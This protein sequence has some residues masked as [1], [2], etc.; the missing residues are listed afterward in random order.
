MEQQYVKVQLDKVSFELRAEVDFT[1]LREMGRVFRVFDQQDSGN[2]SF[3][4]EAQGER[5]FVKYAG[6]R[7]TQYDGNPQDA[8]SR[9][10]NAVPIYYDL[11]HPTL[12]QIRDHFPAGAG[13]AVVFEWYDGECLHPHWS[14]PPPAKYTDPGSPF[15]QYRQLSVE[16]RLKSLDDI[17]KF[18]VFVEEQGYVAVDLYDGSLL[19]NFAQN[20][21]KVCDIDFYQ[22]RPFYNMMGRLWGS[23]R[24]MSPEEYELGAEIDG[25]TNVYNLGAMAFALVGGELDRSRS[26]WEA[27]D[28]L[29]EVASKATQADRLM[30]YAS[31]GEFYREWLEKCDKE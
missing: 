15:Y 1:W 6:A 18:H 2:I 29:Y 3:G 20:T 24:F 8:V 4:V 23:S 21:M 26:K 7:T 22:K 30:R 19:Y 28:E 25:I 9:L 10:Q 16:E 13:Y 11:Q 14:Y 31:V 5:L 27:S 12:I 17:F